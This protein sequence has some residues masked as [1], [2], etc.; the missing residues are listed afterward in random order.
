MAFY[1]SFK[2][3]HAPA[4]L[5]LHTQTVQSR[6]GERKGTPY[7][8]DYQHTVN[9][10]Q[11]RSRRRRWGAARSGL[12]QPTT[13][14]FDR[15]LHD[16]LRHGFN[17]WSFTDFGL[18]RLCFTGWGVAGGA[19]GFCWAWPCRRLRLSRRR[20]WTRA[21]FW[22]WITGLVLGGTGRW[23]WVWELGLQAWRRTEWCRRCGRRLTG[24]QPPLKAKTK[25][26]THKDLNRLMTVIMWHHG[27]SADFK[28]M[29]K[30]VVLLVIPKLVNIKLE[31]FKYQTCPLPL[32]LPRERERENSK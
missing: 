14:D 6:W 9:H 28:V 22:V 3:G 8:V 1:V 10:H 19:A 2:G 21:R 18:L 26:W 12:P 13:S 15:L 25:L 23:P 24:L 29:W 7:A 5:A 17:V 11:P 16:H 30:V 31:P 4:R 27:S 20:R 32:P